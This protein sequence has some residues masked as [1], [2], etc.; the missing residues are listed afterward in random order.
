[1]TMGIVPIKVLSDHDH[2]NDD[3]DLVVS[4]KTWSDMGAV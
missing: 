4:G 1:M 2:S 3:V